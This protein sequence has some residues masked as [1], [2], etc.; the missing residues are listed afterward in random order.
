MPPHGRRAGRNAARIARAALPF[1]LAPWPVAAA[2]AVA[3]GQALQVVLG[4]ALVLALIVAAAWLT[5]RLQAFRP[6]GR[7]QIRIVEGLAIGAR[8]KLLLVEVGDERVLLGL[9]PGRIA[10]LHTFAAP[11]AREFG[12]TLAAAKAAASG[13]AP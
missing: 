6:Q 9:C 12:A 10:T 5:R 7:G 3:P 4:L 13:G 2:E 8:E 1:A 11:P